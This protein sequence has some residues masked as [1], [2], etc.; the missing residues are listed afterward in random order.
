MG[1]LRRERDGRPAASL[2]SPLVVESI[3]NLA[4]YSP[5]ETFNTG[6][7]LETRCYYFESKGGGGG[8]EIQLDSFCI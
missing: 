1:A 2:L 6:T 3:M 7:L 4:N 8:G 5:E